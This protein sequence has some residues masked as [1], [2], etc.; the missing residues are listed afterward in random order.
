MT[1]AAWIATTVS[2][3]GWIVVYRLGLASGRLRATED[4]R[5]RQS[6][7][8]TALL[9]ELRTLEQFMRRLRSST[10]PL[11]A[12]WQIPAPYILANFDRFDLLPA[13][14]VTLLMCLHGK[15]LDV[16]GYRAR[17][18]AGQSHPLPAHW[19]VRLNATYCVHFISQLV[20]LLRAAG[21]QEP[22][23]LPT[24]ITRYPDLP[25][26]PQLAFPDTAFE[27]DEK[28]GLVRAVTDSEPDTDA[29][30]S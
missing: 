29:R 6:Q 27:Y 8:A 4:L 7:M 14:S 5:T 21:G 9:A 22:A 30:T 1:T 25:D 11:F 16:N 2:L 23:A 12:D 28:G 10:T 20:P 13:S 24:E 17:H 19:Y 15:L 26:L 18:A 3:A